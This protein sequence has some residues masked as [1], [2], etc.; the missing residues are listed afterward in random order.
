MVAFQRGEWWGSPRAAGPGRAEAQDRRAGLAWFSQEWAGVFGPRA[1]IF[2]GSVPPSSA[3]AQACP[4]HHAGVCLGVWE[5]PRVGQPLWLSAGNTPRPPPHRQK[6][7]PFAAVGGG[8][9]SQAF[10]LQR[11]ALAAPSEGRVPRGHV[12]A[13][14]V[15]RG[16]RTAPPWQSG[17]GAASWD[18][19]SLALSSVSS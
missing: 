1:G 5:H 12:M 17:E 19:S 18:P 10:G 6:Y 14:G 11:K 3:A 4:D 16:L 9:A 8:E 7:S 13:W 15:H 2:P